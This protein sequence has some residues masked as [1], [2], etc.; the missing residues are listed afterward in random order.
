MARATVLIRIPLASGHNSLAIASDVRQHKIMLS[1][2]NSNAGDRI[3]RANSTASSQHTTSS[4]HHRDS[5]STDPFAA[6]QHAEAAAVEAY[7]RARRYE[8]QQ[9]RPTAHL[10]RRRSQATGRTEGSYFEDARLGRRRSTSTKG[11]SRPPPA[12]RSQHPP[13]VSENTADSAGEEKII[14]RKR[15]VIPP[16][17][18]TTQSHRDHLTAPSATSQRT[19]KS[20][21]VYADGSPV[22]RRSAPLTQRSSTL[23]LSSTPFGEH[24]DGYNGKLGQLSDF[25]EPTATSRTFGSPRPSIRETQTDEEIL[26]LAR[27]KCLQDFQQK[28]VRERKS[29]ILAPFQKRRATA[30]FTASDG[31]YDTMLLPFNHADEFVHAPIPPASESFPMIPITVT[32]SGSKSRNFSDTL[33]GRIKKVFRK[34]SRAPTGLPA[35]QVEAKHFHY[36]VSDDPSMLDAHKNID[37][38]VSFTDE[39]PTASVEQQNASANSRSTEGQRSETKSRVTSWATSTAAGTCN[40][41][42]NGAHIPFADE[43]GGLKRSDSVS[44]LRKAKSFF[45]KPVQNR[46]RRSSKADLKS[47]EESQGLYSA[48]QQRLRP[49]DRNSTP[50]SAGFG[51]ETVVQQSRV[52]S[53][54]ASLPSQ[55]QANNSIS[56][57]KRYSTPTVRSVTPDLK[58]YRLGVCSPVE[59]VLSPDIHETTNTALL[60]PHRSAYPSTEESLPRPR[61]TKAPTPSQEQVQ[62]RMTKSKNRWQS[63]LDELSPHPTRAYTD[64]NPYELRSLSQTHQQPKPT[65]D[66]PHHAKVPQPAPLFDR[67]AMLSPSVYSRASDGASPRP[68]TPVEQAGTVVTITGREVRSYSIS[69]PKQEVA[70]KPA[71]TSGQWRRWLSDEMHGIKSA[72]EDFRLAQVFLD[73]SRDRST[74]GQQ[75]LDGDKARHGSVS[76]LLKVRPGSLTTGAR[77]QSGAS[78]RPRASSRHSSFMNERYPIVD[79]LR[80]SSGESIA[81]RPIR[82]RAG[83]STEQLVRPSIESQ[84]QK[85][86]FSR[87]RVVTGRASIAQMQSIPRDGS[88]DT[89]LDNTMMSGALPAD[90]PT[91][92]LTKDLGQLERQTI[93]VNKH[94]SAFELRANYKSSSNGRSTPL[95]IR[96][97]PMIDNTLNMLE[98]TTIRNISAGPYASHHLPTAA[99]AA[100]NKKE[101]SLPPADINGLPQLS[102]SEWL[103]AGAPNKSRKP[104]SVHPAFRKRDA[105]RYS[106][107]K[108]TPTITRDGGQGSLAQRMASEWLQKRSRESTPAFV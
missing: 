91:V 83:S 3:R 95:E 2:P 17:S 70:P 47:S 26:A 39:T 56:S 53:G 66:L 52:A 92:T 44:T 72:E 100:H 1:R 50:N 20:Q 10:Q 18:T 33:K 14:T 9:A 81:S 77:P 94:K 59:E 29:F 86:G 90:E 41:R 57:M 101:N 7:A 84:G 31:S 49:A 54:L 13:T 43:R 102:S 64:E 71:Q 58:A 15:S 63:P 12:R 27:D 88:E 106:P 34:A 74:S 37:P 98:D 80:N 48:L 75:S 21:S 78:G 79:K 28:K 36:E 69:P 82:S 46:L 99:P 96:R 51:D 8:E 105:S 32:K 89:T 61:V 22:P 68:H 65:N 76:P 25:G 60:A 103:S 45:G 108:A 85:R 87:N 35:Q 42:A 16:S 19:R 38:F 5:T 6:K 55:Q 11:G 67:A 73:S 24:T 40:S 62:R 104:S 4:G 93:K 107:P 23:Q 97:K 30:A